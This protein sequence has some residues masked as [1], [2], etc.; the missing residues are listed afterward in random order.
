MPVGT[1]PKPSKCGVGTVTLVWNIKQYMDDKQ[2]N[3]SFLYDRALFAKV[4]CCCYF[5]NIPVTPTN[6]T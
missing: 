6:N 1:L 4:Y 2:G 5:N 3:R